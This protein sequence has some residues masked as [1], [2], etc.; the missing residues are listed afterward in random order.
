MASELDN[1]DLLFVYGTLHPDRAPAEI[2]SIVRLFRPVSTA[3]ILGRLYDLG[4]YPGVLLDV[5][6][7]EP[8]PGHLFQLPD[9][10]D[11][12]PA[13]DAYEGYDPTGPGTSLYLRQRTQAH[14]PGGSATLCWVYVYN[15]PIP[16]H[17]LA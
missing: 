5:P 13:L 1:P 17:L 6:Q 12:L 15:R 8:I 10:P 11:A 9:L 14:L 2:A 3:T 16:S 7:P 4:P